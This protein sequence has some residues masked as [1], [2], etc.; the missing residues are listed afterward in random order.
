MTILAQEEPSANLL[1][2]HSCIDDPRYDSARAITCIASTDAPVTLWKVDQFTFRY[3]LAHHN[4]AE[5]RPLKER[6]RQID[7][8]KDMNE[9][10]VSKFVAGMTR[11]RWKQGDQIVVKGEVGNVFYV[12]EEG[13]VKIHD[14][15][16]GDSKFDDQILGA[17]ESFGERALLTG[18]PR[19]ANVTALT[20]VITRAMDRE[21]FERSIGPLQSVMERH[22]RR[23][24]L[25]SLPL[26]SHLNSAEI[27]QLVDLMVEVCY[28]KDEKLAEAGK[29]YETLLW[30]IRHGRLLVFSTKETDTIY[31][32]GSGDHYGDKSIRHPGRIS[33]HNA[34]CEEE[35]TAWVL[36]RDDIESVVGDIERLGEP[37]QLSMTR[38]LR[39]LAG[40]D[41]VKVRILGQGAFGR[42]WL[43]KTKEEPTTSAF[44]LKVISKRLILES[45]QVQGVIREKQ[46]LSLFHNKFIVHLVSAF[47][48]GRNLY[49]VLPLIPGGELYS[50]LQNQKSRSAGLPNKSAA[51]YVACVL[52]ALVHF[53]QRDV[54]YRDL[55]LENILI[56]DRGYCQIVD[57]GFAKVV[58][59][60]TFTLVGTVS[61]LGWR[62][63]QATSSSNQ[64]FCY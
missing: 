42:V 29:P 13:Q 64:F 15:G 52:E 63:R 4:H 36:T 27:D 16:L 43:V 11:I 55:K 7:I 21:T 30:I 10:V 57:L 38:Q 14:I 46:L 34:V 26:F 32:L 18:E 39:P 1:S 51:F 37:T 20:D 54:A 17:G 50:V 41:L 31:S 45:K 2:H 33:S 53:H 49:L 25:S 44:A 9:S 56:D 48:D 23:Q 24:Y 19:A 61:T 60:K 22:V 62:A 8:F 35:L 12:I 40:K 5:D 47:Q 28:C 3:L 58:T 59:E 6:I